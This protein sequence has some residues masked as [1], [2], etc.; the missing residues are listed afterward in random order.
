MEEQRER[1]HVR[2]S[3]PISKKGAYQAEVSPGTTVGTVLAAAMEHFEV[4]NDS[5]FTY[6]LAFEGQ[7]QPPSE[8]VGALAGDSD[9]VEFTMV[10]KIT[11]G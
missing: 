8:G 9:R 6:V 11:Q 2:V 7:E 4:D 3:F 1:L 5:Q 10:K